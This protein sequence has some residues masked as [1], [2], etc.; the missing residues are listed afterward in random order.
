[1]LHLNVSTPHL[2]LSC[3]MFLILLIALYL[4]MALRLSRCHI[5]QQRIGIQRAFRFLLRFSST[6]VLVILMLNLKYLSS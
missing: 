1:M 6:K 2:R 3:M 4:A 5:D